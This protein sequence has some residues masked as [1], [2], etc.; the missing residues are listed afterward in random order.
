M[1]C[2]EVESLLLQSEMEKTPDGVFV[3][4]A[5][6]AAREVAD[7]LA[8]C[9]ACSQLARKLR[10]LEKAVRSLPEPI[11]MLD[12]KNAFMDHLQNVVDDDEA[13]FDRTTDRTHVPAFTHRPY[14]RRRVVRKTNIFW[15][16]ADSRVTAAALVLMVITGSIWTYRYREE[17]VL[18]SA[19]ALNN[20]VEW[21]LRLAEH[22]NK[23]ERQRLYAA[24]A[25]AE[26]QLAMHAH[27]NADDR[28]QADSLIQS[29]EFLSTNE[30]P[31]AEADHF[32][33]IADVLITKMGFIA[34]KAPE[35]LARFSDTYLRVVDDGI[36]KNLDRAE[37]SGNDTP[38]TQKQVASIDRRDLLL[39]L[40]VEAILEKNPAPSQ[41]Q[42]R[43]AL[44]I[45]KQYTE[46]HH[47]AIK[48]PK[49]QPAQQP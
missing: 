29:G 38:D 2:Q 7:H 9:A 15:R 3:R 33:Q 12:S 47:S 19:Q 45:Q 40:K 20:L 37:A 10:R 42:L 1:N 17:Q 22:N 23:L 35:T 49:P 30:D 25:E 21:N 24:R 36:H 4:F 18:A 31:L 43:K 16:V 39:Q 27:L 41:T 6:D 14:R 48:P 5:G 28:R 8:T 11:G 32:S 44:A 26:R 34:T 46:H 13:A